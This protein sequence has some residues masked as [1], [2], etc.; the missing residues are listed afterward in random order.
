MGFKQ[1]ETSLCETVATTS[2][3]DSA[4]TTSAANK[5]NLENLITS[6]KSELAAANALLKVK[7]S[8]CTEFNVKVKRSATES[9]ETNK[10][11][12]SFEKQ[13]ENYRETV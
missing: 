7:E 3:D 4:T 11:F 2:E 13:C 8:E 5:T 6:L 10:R 12:A 1:I 9:L